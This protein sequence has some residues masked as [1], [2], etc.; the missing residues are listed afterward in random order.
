MDPEDSAAGLDEGL[1]DSRAGAE[2]DVPKARTEDSGAGTEDLKSG[3]E[4]AR[5]GTGFGVE[6]DDLKAETVVEAGT[7]VE[8]GADVYDYRTETGG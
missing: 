6:Q 2:K 7:D 8:G 4:D 3:T 5:A 1:G